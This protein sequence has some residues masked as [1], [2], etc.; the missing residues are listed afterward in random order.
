M[1][2]YGVIKSTVPAAGTRAG[3]DIALAVVLVLAVVLDVARAVVL[4]LADLLAIALAVVL[5]L[6]VLIDVAFAGPCLYFTNLS[7]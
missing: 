4:A 7:N 1:C 6:A 2:E 5:V 3:A